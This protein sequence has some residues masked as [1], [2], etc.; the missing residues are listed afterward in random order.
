MKRRD[1][2]AAAAAS[3]T[4]PGLARFADRQQPLLLRGGTLVDGLGGPSSVTDVLIRDDRISAVGNSLDRP[5]G[6]RVVDVDGLI[7]APGFIDPH[8]HTDGELLTDATA[9][10]KIRQGVTTE[11]TGQDGGSRGVWR[12]GV[13]DGLEAFLRRV[14]GGGSS[15]NIATM[16]GAGTVRGHVLGASNVPASPSDTERMRQLVQEAIEGGAVGLSSGLE[17]VPGAFAS[18][19]EIVA[20][21]APLVEAELPYAT[22]MRNEDDRLLAATEEALM[23][24]KRAGVHVH[25]SHLKAQGVRN[26]WKAAAA[27]DMVDR[28]IEDGQSVTIDRYPYIAYSTG[29]ASLFPVE[30]R[31]GGSAAF[32]SRLESSAEQDRLRASVEGKVAKMGDWNVVQVTSVTSARN[33]FSVG[34]RIG[35]LA[36]ERG[37]DP[38]ALVVEILTADNGSTGMIGFGMSEE[39]TERILA[40]PMTMVCSD[41]SALA[42]EGPLSSGS[43]HPRSFGSFPRFLGHYIR[44]RGIV[45]LEDGIRKITSLPAQVFKLADRGVI[46]EGAFADLVL[47]DP[48]TIA[49]TATFSTPHSYPTGIEY[50]LVNG[51]L[52]VERGEHTGATPGRVLLHG[53]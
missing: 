28:A 31:D 27:L 50:V 47:F 5:A 33:A 12:D 8:S 42:T 38:Y 40:H 9:Q 19:D 16:L 21:C 7:V 23:I 14:S 3:V 32:A 29:L 44:N 18:T 51:R 25:I 43:P 4:L 6:G 35:D 2:V 49:D 48:E 39:N 22:H 53:R 41:G 13:G 34:R 11:I 15:V 45:T 36:S 17:Y 52:V 26:W 24:G 46:R 37:V 10:S 20:I 30:A 1:F